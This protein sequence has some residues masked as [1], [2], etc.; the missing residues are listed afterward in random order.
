M[1]TIT[2]RGA[3]W[4][5]DPRSGNASSAW[6]YGETPKPAGKRQKKASEGVQG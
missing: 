6:G 5:K 3:W 2:E 1:G 4:G